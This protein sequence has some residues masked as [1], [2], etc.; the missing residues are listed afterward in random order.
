MGVLAQQCWGD[1]TVVGCSPSCARRTLHGVGAHPAVLL[2]P[3]GALRWG[4][5]PTCAA[6]ISLRDPR[7]GASASTVPRCLL[8]SS[9]GA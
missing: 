4:C 8:G 6:P 1:P 9:P 5:I 3:A 2:L 7:A